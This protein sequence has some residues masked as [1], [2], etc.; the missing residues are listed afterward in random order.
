MSMAVADETLKTVCV[1]A[2]S[3]PSNRPGRSAAPSTLI[4]WIVTGA[5]LRDGGRLKL[6]ATRSPGGWLTSEAWI[7]EFLGALTADRAGDV[8]PSAGAEMRAEA[9]MARM[10]ARGFQAK[11]V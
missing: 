6:R 7:Q 1:A 4:R 10:A 2:R 3:V 9:A 8:A 11:G 5:K